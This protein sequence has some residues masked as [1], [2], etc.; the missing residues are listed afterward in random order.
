VIEQL[1]YRKAEFSDLQ[2]ILNLLYEDELG[3]TRELKGLEL[4]PL[5]EEAFHKI[6]A[7]SKHYLMVVEKGYEIVGTCHLTFMHSLTFLGSMRMQ[8]EAVRVKE[9]YRGCKIGN[10]MIKAA[11]ALGQSKGA[12]IIQLTT[13]KKRLQ[14]QKFYEQLGFEQSHEGFK[15]Y[16]AE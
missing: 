4:N 12:K 8:I 3:K 2:D 14:A 7:D 15:M 9:K 16:V 13:H 11:I 5:Y 6:N 1:T 10:W